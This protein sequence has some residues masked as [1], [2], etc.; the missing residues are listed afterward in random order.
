MNHFRDILHLIT[1]LFKLVKKDRLVEIGHFLVR[2]TFPEF[3][4]NFKP[5][6]LSKVS[7]FPENWSHYLKINSWSMVYINLILHIACIPIAGPMLRVS[8]DF[9]WRTPYLCLQNLCLQNI[10]LQNICY[11]NTNFI[12]YFCIRQ[13]N[14]EKGDPDW[15]F[16]IFP[17]KFDTKLKNETS[18][19]VKSYL[20]YTILSVVNPKIRQ[21]RNFVT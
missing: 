5:R 18:S 14:G 4:E 11:R 19:V 6:I 21:T 9:F 10:T 2:Y 15:N 8:A 12:F 20:R 17:V 16:R 3:P 13:K 1:S 7:K